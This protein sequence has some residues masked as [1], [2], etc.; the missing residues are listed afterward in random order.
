N[1]PVTQGDLLVFELGWVNHA[2]PATPTD[3]LGDTFTL[4][5]SVSVTGGGSTYYSYI[6]YAIA[7]HTGVDTIS[8][9]FGA[10]VGGSV[11]VDEL[12]GYTTTAYTKSTGSSSAGSTSAAVTSFN[13]PATNSIVIGH[14]QANGAS[15]QSISPGGTFN[16]DGGCGSGIAC[17]EYLTGAGTGGTTVPFTLSP[18]A[19]PWAETAIAFEPTPAPVTYYSYIWTATAGSSGADTI[20]ATFGA[21]TPGS[22]SLYE[23][24]GATT[25]G[26]QSSTGSS[27]VGSTTSSVTSFTPSASSIVIGNSE[28][29]PPVGAFTA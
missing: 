26:L 19:S 28:S 10:S 17:S 4:G 15:G 23:I 22:I 6:W 1:S 13:P 21:T 20:T 14:I 16:Q 18:S 9:T 24:S 27:A 25:T 29:G 3:T 5:P 12:S 11:W 8:A 7:V 2:A